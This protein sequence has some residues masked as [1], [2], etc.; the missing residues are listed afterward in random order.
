MDGL[1]RLIFNTGINDAD[2]QVKPRDKSKGCPFYR[3]WMDMLMRCYCS[4]YQERNPAYKG[5]TVCEEW[6][7]FSNF[8]KWMETQ[9]W[10]GLDLDKDLINPGNRVYCPEFCIFVP[11]DVNNMFRS[12]KSRT[13]PLGVVLYRNGKY[14]AQGD[15]SYLGYYSTPEQAHDVWKEFKRNQITRRK[16]ELDSID[17]RLF[18][19]LLLK[20]ED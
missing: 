13:L 1:M 14:M 16:L 6:L 2:Y 17:A 9:S 20:I 11:R 19:A 18:G 5:A 4:Y 8:K 12:S 15:G 10:E 7:T 3:K